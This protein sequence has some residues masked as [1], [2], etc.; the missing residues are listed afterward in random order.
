MEDRD[1]E[2]GGPRGR[3]QVTGVQNGDWI[4]VD[5]PSV[6]ERFLP[7][8]KE[9]EILFERFFKHRKYT[10][11]DGSEQDADPPPDQL[12][13]PGTDF[14]ACRHCNRPKE[15]HTRSGWVDMESTQVPHEYYESTALENLEKWVLYTQELLLPLLRDRQA[16]TPTPFLKSLSMFV[17][18][19]LLCQPLA[20][21]RCNHL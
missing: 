6:G 4:A 12:L 11:H 17:S 20:T 13:P 1:E 7:I 2:N 15:E 8:K 16:S 21:T 5:V 19:R 18:F 10:C 9:G 14:S 3:G